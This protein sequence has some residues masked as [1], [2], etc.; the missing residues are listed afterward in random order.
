MDHT[1]PIS[2]SR[3]RRGLGGGAAA[4]ASAAPARLAK[5][6]IVAI[7]FFLNLFLK[8]KGP[9]I[10]SLEQLPFL[11]AFTIGPGQDFPNPSDVQFLTA[12]RFTGELLRLVIVHSCALSVNH[13]YL[14]AF[15]H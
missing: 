8:F 4:T 7:F 11:Q 14:G 10:I 3:Q 1:N 5:D 9:V 13:P 6:I 15:I 2:I 12:E